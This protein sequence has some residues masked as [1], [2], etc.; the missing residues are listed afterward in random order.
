MRQPLKKLRRRWRFV[1]SALATRKESREEEALRAGARQP[2]LPAD[3]KDDATAVGSAATRRLIVEVRMTA[4]VATATAEPEAAAAAAEAGSKGSA[5]AARVRKAT[6]RVIVPRSKAT[7][8]REVAWLT[9]LWQRLT[10]ASF[11]RERRG[12]AR[13][14]LRPAAPRRAEELF[15]RGCVFPAAQKTAHF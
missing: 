7:M 9:L 15:S 6:R 10:L 5:S 12:P 3:L 14:S 4:E 2:C 8:T 11:A 1:V 13:A